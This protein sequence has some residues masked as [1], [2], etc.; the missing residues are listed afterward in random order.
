MLPDT[1]KN[2]K[3]ESPESMIILADNKIAEAER[4][5]SCGDYNAAYYHAGYPVELYLK[6]RIC[7]TLKI[8]NFFDFGNRAKFINEDSVTKPYKVHNFEQ[9]LLLSGLIK[10]HTIEMENSL[11]EADWLILKE[12][13]E[14]TRYAT[15]MQKEK[16]INFI[17]STKNFAVWIKQHL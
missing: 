7:I 5:Y 12:W 13:K 16:V 8:D 2:I 6:A 1:Y 4:M 11:F 14:D 10:E 17:T 9:L 15:G 3:L